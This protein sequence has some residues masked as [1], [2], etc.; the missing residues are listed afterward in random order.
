[1]AKDDRLYA[2]FTLDFADSPKIAPLSD[3]A[4][5][6]YV[7][8]VLWSRRL[9]TDGLIPSGMVRK[10]FAS[11]S[12][13]EL[14]SN[15]AERPSL[16]A[17]EGG[18]QIHHFLDQ[19]TSKAEIEAMK[20]NKRAAGARGGR[21]K[22]EANHSPSS[23]LAPAS[24]VPDVRYPGSASRRGSKTYPETE[25]ETE[26]KTSTTDVVERPA[27]RGS[28]LS[29]DWMPSAASIAKAKED[30]PQVDHK[31]E[32]AT[33]VDYWIAQPGQKGV[34]TDWEAT[35]R[36]WMRRKQG[37]TRTTTARRSVTK[38]DQNAALYHELYGGGN[39][40]ARSFPA[41]DAGLST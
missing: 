22:A 23:G 2:K 9:L 39:E 35:W 27:K 25:T 15:D 7:E 8:A 24:P 14:T 19:Q 33:F 31:A 18:L 5:R 12:I 37:D 34:K 17:V 32:H 4:F 36:N 3:A 6:Q 20:E 40:R 29:P 28:R 21:A 1:M 10:L 26:T 30:A 16:V 11:E 13:A 38:A 41:I